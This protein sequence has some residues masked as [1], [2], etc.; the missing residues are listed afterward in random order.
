MYILNIKEKP[1]NGCSKLFGS[2]NSVTIR[3][4]WTE[5]YFYVKLSLISITRAMRD[6]MNIPKAKSSE[7][8]I[9]IRIT[10]SQ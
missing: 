10:S 5:F 1:M 7:S 2:K 9:Y 6:I 8:V 3:G 4:H